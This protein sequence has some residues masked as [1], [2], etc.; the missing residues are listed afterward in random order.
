MSGSTRSLEIALKLVESGYEV[1]ILTAS[2][3][4]Q[5]KFPKQ[6]K[7]IDLKWYKL[8]YSNELGFISRIL[9]FLL[10]VLATSLSVLFKKYDIIYCSSTPLS[11]GVPALI[12]SYLRGKPFI[13]EVRD[14]WP[15]IPISMGFI[16]SNTLKFVLKKFA[17]ECYKRS[18]A[19]VALSEDMKLEIVEN[20]EILESKI[21]VAENG[22]RADY[23]NF[24]ST[25]EMEIRN[26]FDIAKETKIVIYPGALGRVNEVGYIAD[27]ASFINDEFAFLI[28][29]DG[30]QRDS[31]LK[32]SKS[33]GTLNRNLF[34]LNGVTKKL[35]FEYIAIAD[36]LISTVAVIPKLDQNSANKFFDG[37]RSGKCILINYGGWQANFIEKNN[38]GL[39]L[40]RNPSS[41]AKQL[42]EL[43]G[44]EK[45]LQEFKRNAE[46][47]SRY[48]EMDIIT[49]K[50]VEILN[51]I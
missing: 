23:F 34:Y 51:K 26:R 10:F 40:S 17:G 16:K 32:S 29:G 20:Y 5:S 36:C 48:F 15:E 37:L 50:I 14:V 41:A 18:N 38:C 46:I 33:N 9:L 21:L 28:V 30:V 45:R 11:V 4:G 39:V 27:L 12:A 22:S 1:E 44:N 6:Y 49:S 31:L 25:F 8:P 35:I 7:G 19:I 2:R 13:F 47:S 24:D 3:Y 42:L 43:Y